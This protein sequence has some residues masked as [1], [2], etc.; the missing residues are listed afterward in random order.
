[1]SEA[2]IN[3]LISAGSGLLG[4]MV[5][6]ILSYLFQLRI[7][8]KRKAYERSEK[9]QKE[10]LDGTREF[11]QKL[12]GHGAELISLEQSENLFHIVMTISQITVLACILIGFL[13][14]FPEFQDF[15]KSLFL[16]QNIL[17]FA[18]ITLVGFSIGAI[19]VSIYR[20]KKD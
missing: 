15:L 17:V 4:V 7:D 6:S 1:M 8:K 13:A 18:F 20:Q 3:S 14:L 9:I 19:L 10:L 2:T 16:E 12:R 5:G 11:A